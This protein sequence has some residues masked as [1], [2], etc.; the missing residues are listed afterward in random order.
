MDSEHDA[1]IA[2]WSAAPSSARKRPVSSPSAN[3]L[4][5]DTMPPPADPLALSIELITVAEFLANYGY[6]TNPNY[7]YSLTWLATSLRTVVAVDPT[8]SSRRHI[9]ASPALLRSTR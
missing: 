8:A 9:S 7:F 4:R 1:K 5:M 3:K 6:K 2:V